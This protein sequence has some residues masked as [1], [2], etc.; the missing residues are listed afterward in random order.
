VDVGDIADVSEVHVVSI[1]R[2]EVCRVVAFLCIYRILF[3]NKISVGEG[4][5]GLVPSLGHYEH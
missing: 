1:F 5:W 4:K 3:R 2:F